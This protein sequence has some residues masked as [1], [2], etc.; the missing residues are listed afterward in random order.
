[1]E[2]SYGPTMQ[3]Y[4][5]QEDPAAKKTKTGRLLD[6]DRQGSNLCVCIIVIACTLQ[7]DSNFF[8]TD[9]DD[10]ANMHTHTHREFSLSLFIKSAS[11]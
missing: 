1:M 9:F 2:Y 11:K 10:C 5:E 4:K 8:R 6:S 3:E 7:C